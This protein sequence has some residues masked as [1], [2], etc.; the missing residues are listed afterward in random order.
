[1][2]PGVVRFKDKNFDM[3]EGAVIGVYTDYKTNTLNIVVWDTNTKEKVIIPHAEVSYW[4]YGSLSKEVIADMKK[5]L[6]NEGEEKEY[7][8]PYKIGDVIKVVRAVDNVLQLVG[9]TLKIKKVYDSANEESGGWA[10]EFDREDVLAFHSEV[11]LV[12]KGA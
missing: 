6:D 8:G 3:Y 1:M 7:E 9:K 12:K 11:Q 4:S 5:H 10:Y 2:R